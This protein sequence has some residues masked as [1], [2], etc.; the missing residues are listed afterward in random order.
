MLGGGIVIY[1]YRGCSD[2]FHYHDEDE[3][4]DDGVTVGQISALIGVAVQLDGL[5]DIDLPPFSIVLLEILPLGTLRQLGVDVLAVILVLHGDLLGIERKLRFSVFEILRIGVLG[6]KVALAIF[7]NQPRDN[8][9]LE[10]IRLAIS[11]S[12]FNS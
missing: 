10:P 4:D 8:R 6:R 7:Q 1:R 11:K 2:G 5:D 9:F 12:E 3:E